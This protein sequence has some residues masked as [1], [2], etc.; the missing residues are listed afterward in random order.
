VGSNGGGIGLYGDPVVAGRSVYVGDDAQTLDVYSAL[1]ASHGKSCRP[2]WCLNAGRGYVGMGV[3]VADGVVVLARQVTG[4]VAYPA[5]CG[6]DRGVCTPLWTA[7]MPMTSSIGAEP[8]TIANGV[9]YFAT[10]ELFAVSLTCGRGGA[11]CPWL[12][13]QLIGH[14][15]GLGTNPVVLGRDV[16]VGSAGGGIYDHRVPVGAAN[17]TRR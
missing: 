17:P 6:A 15:G 8:P 11:T 10:D 16:L 5:Q 4:L 1:C 12:W 7:S 9:V 3:A 2:A 14:G 13:Q